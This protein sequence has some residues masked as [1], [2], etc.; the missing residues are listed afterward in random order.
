[1]RF[2]GHDPD[3]TVHPTSVATNISNSP[4]SLD[5][6]TGVDNAL[7]LRLG[8]FQNHGEPVTVTVGF[9]AGTLDTVANLTAL[10][11]EADEALYQ[12]KSRRISAS[13]GAQR[14]TGN[15]TTTGSVRAKA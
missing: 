7:I 15:L 8:C 5:V 2:A 3:D 11:K 6:S 1:M 4:E 13:P 12:T 14:L 9:A 10:Y